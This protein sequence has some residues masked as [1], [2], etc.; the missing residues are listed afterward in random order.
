[1]EEGYLQPSNP[2]LTNMNSPMIV[3]LPTQTFLLSH[4]KYLPHIEALTTE[5]LVF[6]STSQNVSFSM[7]NSTMVNTQ[8]SD[9]PSNYSTLVDTIGHN[10]PLADL[11]QF[12]R[13]DLNL[14]P[15][16]LSH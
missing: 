6:P 2:P 8:P 14:V 15:D 13:L 5:S 4:Q 9:I 10:R 12:G 16:T 1:M 11:N 3:E 7:A